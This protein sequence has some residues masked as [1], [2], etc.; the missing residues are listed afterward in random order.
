MQ[1]T[2]KNIALLNSLNQIVIMKQVLKN[3]IK[4]NRHPHKENIKFILEG[5]QTNPYLTE[6]QKE[7]LAKVETILKRNHWLDLEKV[8]DRLHYV[9]IKE[10]STYMIPKYVQQD[11]TL[12]LPTGFPLEEQLYL[13]L[14]PG[15]PKYDNL[16]QIY[17][18]YMLNK[19][20][21]KDPFYHAFQ[22]LV[23][24]V[25]PDHLDGAMATG[26]AFLLLP[27]LMVDHNIKKAMSLLNE[28]TGYYHY[29]NLGEERI[30]KIVCKEKYFSLIQEV[31]D[32]KK[33]KDI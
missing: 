4:N 10:D 21:Q 28:L 8:Y 17:S 13:L 20:N 31:Y 16:N 26:N 23:Q 14:V 15:I 30:E 33:C 3:P 2:T 11:R 5:I 12:Y 19:K 9:K 7:I 24:V 22:R 18:A 27:D 25:S 32:Q 29:R 6:I 1:V